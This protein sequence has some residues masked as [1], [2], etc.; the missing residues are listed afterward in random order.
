MSSSV[1]VLHS[2]QHRELLGRGQA[3]W[4]FS[5]QVRGATTLIPSGVPGWDLGHHGPETRG[6]GPR[7]KHR[8][9]RLRPSCNA[10]S[11]RSSEPLLEEGVLKIRP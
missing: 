10:R 7:G 4:L 2:G 8:H 11:H 6:E 9:F 3:V 5:L 1:P